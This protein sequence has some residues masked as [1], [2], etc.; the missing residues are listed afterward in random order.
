[1]WIGHNA[2]RPGLDRGELGLLFIT[3]HLDVLLYPSHLTPVLFT[4][5]TAPSSP[6]SGTILSNLM[7]IPGITLAGH[8]D[9]C[10]CCSSKV[11][12]HNYLAALEHRFRCLSSRPLVHN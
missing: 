6:F 2:L 9:R 7:K 1:M 8:L 5:T 11:S 12:Q 4:C 10:Y 3:S